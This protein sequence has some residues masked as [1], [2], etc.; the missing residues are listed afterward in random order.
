[1]TKNLVGLKDDPRALE[2]AK[3]I[4]DQKVIALRK[5]DQAETEKNISDLKK[6]IEELDYDI[7]HIDQVVVRELDKLKPFFK[8]RTLKVKED[9]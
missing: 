8:E 7:A 4:C 6:H 3:Y 9:A 5:V 1:M 2:G